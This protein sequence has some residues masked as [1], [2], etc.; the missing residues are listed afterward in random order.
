V[1]PSRWSCLWLQADHPGVSGEAH[2]NRSQQAMEDLMDST[3]PGV[4]F[5]PKARSSERRKGAEEQNHPSLHRAVERVP[6]VPVQV[7]YR[8]FSFA[9]LSSGEEP[10]RYA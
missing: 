2:G 5:V 4:S 1:M 7:Y 3:H 10:N 6:S 9:S 8:R